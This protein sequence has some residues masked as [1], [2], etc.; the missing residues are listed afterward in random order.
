MGKG[1]SDNQLDNSSNKKV[2]D[3]LF[4]IGASSLFNQMQHFSI[5]Q[6]YIPNIHKNNKV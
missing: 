2:D 1:I 3:D 5:E 6:I 4:M